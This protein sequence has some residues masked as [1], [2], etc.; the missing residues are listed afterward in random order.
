MLS[1]WSQSFKK[2]HHELVLSG[3]LREDLMILV[4]LYCQ[5]DP[6]IPGLRSC[7]SKCARPPTTCSS[8]LSMGYSHTW[9]RT[10]TSRGTCVITQPSTTCPTHL[11]MGFLPYL[12]EH[13]D[14]Q[15]HLCELNYLLPICLICRWDFSHTWLRTWTNRGTFATTRSSTPFLNHLS[16]GFLPYLAEHLDK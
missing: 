10:W 3:H 14:E 2:C 1:A 15:R 11:P 8:H 16:T 7:T 5:W 9:M 13:L 12:V 6:P 4:R